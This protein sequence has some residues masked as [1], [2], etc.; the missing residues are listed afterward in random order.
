MSCGVR[1]GPGSAGSIGATARLQ[2]PGLEGP[3]RRQCRTVLRAYRSCH[4]PRALLCAVFRLN[5]SI[6]SSS[7]SR[8]R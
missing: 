7:A 2:H 8:F 5:I 3:E 4:V 1:E 6:G